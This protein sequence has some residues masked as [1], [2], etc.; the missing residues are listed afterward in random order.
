MRGEGIEFGSGRFRFALLV[1]LVTGVQNIYY[2]NMF[3]QLVLIGGLLQGWRHGWRAMLPSVSIV[4]AMAGAFLLMNANTF[5]YHLVNGGNSGTLMRNYHWLEIYGLKLV[6]L[7]VPPPDHPFPPF[8]KWAA[9]HLKEV[10]LSPGESPPS[11]Y[12]GVLGLGALAWLMAVSLRRVADRARIPLEAWLILWIIIYAQVGGING[13]IGT[14]GFQLFR[15]TTRYSIFILCIVLMFA[16]G[17]LSLAKVRHKFLAYGAALVVV[18]IALWDQTP[19]LVS[20]GELAET[21]QAV[22][23][24]REF[25]EKMEKRLPAQA[26]I[27][28]IPVMDFPENMAPGIPPYDHFRP[29]LYSHHLRFSFGS[30][31]GR[32]HEKWQHDLVHL[33]LGDAVSRLE[34]YGF[35][36]LYVNLSGLADDGAGMIEQF[37]NMGRA[38]MFTSDRGDLLCVLLKPSAQPVLPDGY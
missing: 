35:S 4:A 9:V 33:S 25:T 26:M 17:R 29:Y 1:A 27:F 2:T 37:K 5:A 20:A 14:L 19:P 15:T 16:V 7:V 30:D 3:A 21:A 23:S 13:I 6:D 32:P 11:A 36:A 34:S 22:A 8:A 24:D 10:V 18:G 31:K 38:D 28:Q 12:L